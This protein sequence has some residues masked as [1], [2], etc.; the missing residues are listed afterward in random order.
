M[1]KSHEVT[2]KF[3]ETG[4][5]WRLWE[6]GGRI[7]LA[8]SGGVDSMV[9]ADLVRRLPARERPKATVIHYDHRLRGEESTTDAEFV[10]KTCGLWGFPVVCGAAPAWSS[11]ENLQ[12]RA[13]KLRYD[14]FCEEMRRQG[15]DRLAT[16]HQADDQAETFLIRWV[17]GSGL[18]GFAG[19]PV[20]R[21]VGNKSPLYIVRPLLFV[22]RAEIVDYAERFEVPYREDSSNRKGNY[23][24][25]RIRGILRELK[26]RN[27]SLARRSA[28]NSIL[29]KADEEFLQGETDRIAGAA[30]AAGE[31]GSFSVSRFKGLPAAIRYRLL[32]RMY[33]DLTGRVLGSEPILTLDRLLRDPAPCRKFNLP[34]RVLFEKEYVT[35]RFVQE[36]PATASDSRSP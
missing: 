19:I 33:R 16:A 2:K 32:Q 25:N 13:R 29:L 1:S 15:I 3:R 31:A 21:Q 22:T 28:V 6:P 23:L 7:L 27:P 35:F 20:L 8:V 4:I 10:E 24:R 5:R 11:K 34:E 12:E 9:M 17:Q 36:A 18:K 30:G 26:Q 14:F